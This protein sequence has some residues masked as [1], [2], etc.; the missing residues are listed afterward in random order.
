MWRRCLIIAQFFTSGVVNSIATVS[1]ETQSVHIFGVRAHFLSSS[2][3]ISMLMLVD[4][5]CNNFSSFSFN[6]AECRVATVPDDAVD[7]LV[8]V[9]GSISSYMT[10]MVAQGSESLLF[11]VFL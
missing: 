7:Q 2:L 1:V 8:I 5:A 9:S 11:G 10:S 3:S 6:L 4:G